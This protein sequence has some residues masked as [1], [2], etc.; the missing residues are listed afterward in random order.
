MYIFFFCFIMVVFMLIYLSDNYLPK[1]NNFNNYSE[2]YTETICGSIDNY[3]TI[4]FVIN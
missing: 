4:L 1:R 3:K 2:H